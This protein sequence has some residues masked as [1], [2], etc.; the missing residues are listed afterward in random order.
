M[1]CD[2]DADHANRVPA[3][4]D[5]GVTLL[6]SLGG[7]DRIPQVKV[8]VLVKS[9]EDAGKLH[10]VALQLEQDPLADGIIEIK[11]CGGFVFHNGI[12]ISEI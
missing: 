7:L 2:L 5:V 12:K 8:Q 4:D 10:A 6:L 3:Q 1:D 9:L 11:L